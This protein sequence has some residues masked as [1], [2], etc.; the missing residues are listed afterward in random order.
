M[1]EQLWEQQL[2]GNYYQHTEY[3]YG[4]LATG[5]GNENLL[6]ENISPPSLKKK[7]LR[8]NAESFIPKFQK[9][10]AKKKGCFQ[11]K[12]CSSEK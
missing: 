9:G 2:H 10:S 6:P 5:N 1:E 4:N 3:N 11:K 7:T 8:Y 12:G